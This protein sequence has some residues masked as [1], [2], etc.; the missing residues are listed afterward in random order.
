MHLTHANLL[1]KTPWNHSHVGFTRHCKW[2][3]EEHDVQ[4]RSNYNGTWRV[5]VYWLQ[6]LSSLESYIRI[7]DIPW[8]PS[9]RIFVSHAESPR[10]KVTNFQSISDCTDASNISE[11]D[12]HTYK[13]I[14]KEYIQPKISNKVIDRVQNSMTSITCSFL[15]G[16]SKK[17]SIQSKALCKRSLLS[18]CSLNI[19]R[20][21]QINYSHQMKSLTAT[22]SESDR[23][24]APRRPAQTSNADSFQFIP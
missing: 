19:K 24:T 6:E 18:K 1:E 16:P 3:E 21:H 5:I 10:R 12:I 14:L 22:D 15:S 2:A 4:P 13:K 9:I 20:R 23:A 11:T 7:E 17:Q 8:P